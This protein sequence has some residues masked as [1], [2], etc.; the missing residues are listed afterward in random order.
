MLRFAKTI[1][2]LKTF[3]VAAFLLTGAHGHVRSVAPSDSA[4]QVAGYLF[5]SLNNL[6]DPAPLVVESTQG[7]SGAA[8]DDKDQ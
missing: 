8:K 6:A 4:C 7:P 1:A 3:A 2:V 5:V